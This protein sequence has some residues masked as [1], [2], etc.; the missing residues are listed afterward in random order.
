MTKATPDYLNCRPEIV[1]GLIETA[2]DALLQTFPKVS[3]GPYDIELMLDALRVLRPKVPEIQM[4]DGI[5]HMVR[6]HWD[7]AILV[8]REVSESAPR[9]AYAK[10]L[11]A[12]CLSTK[13][14]GDW[15]LIANEVLENNPTRD[16]LALVK[17]LHAREEL[18]SAVNA[19]RNGGAFVPP[20]SI[21][22]L[23]EELAS[24]GDKPDV[25]TAPVPPAA[26]LE[27]LPFGVA[28]RA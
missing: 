21:E 5:L 20:A 10:A 13:G 18:V 1:G 12:F 9:F 8:L 25:P 19:S 27:S 2:S 26:G 15:K 14:D 24:R 28:L 4:L 11:L 3:V 17:A 7:D 6:N 16:T 22:E 23:N